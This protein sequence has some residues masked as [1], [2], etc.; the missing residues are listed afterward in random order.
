MGK[1]FGNPEELELAVVV[2]G[3]EIEGGPAAEVGRVTT[4]IDGYIPDVAGEDANEFALRMTQLV[5]EPAENAACGKRLIV[6]SED[7]RKTEGGEG[8]RIKKLSEPAALVA[9]A[10]GLQDFH[11]AQGGLT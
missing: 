6:L 7:R 11:I 9:V 8:V 3:L 4:E 10:P 2:E 5:V 1:A